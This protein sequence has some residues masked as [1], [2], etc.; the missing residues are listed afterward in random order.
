MLTAAQLD[1]SIRESALSSFRLYLSRRT[2]FTNLDLLRLWKGLFSCMWLTANPLPQQRLAQDLASLVPG[3]LHD[4]NVLIFLDTFWETMSREWGGIDYL[5]I[6]K[7]M[8]LARLMLREQLAWLKRKD[9]DAEQVEKHNGI[10]T[11]TPLNVDNAKIPNGLRY[12]VL[13]VFVDELEKVSESSANSRLKEQSEM[14]L[15]KLLE[16]VAELAKKSPLKP[17]RERAKNAL[18]DDR[19]KEWNKAGAPQTLSGAEGE[20]DSGS[21]W[22]GFEDD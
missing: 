14:P 9:W 22:S 1:P 19:L 11:K 8:Y 21:D 12:H 15:G 13:D 18:A 5:R 16:P 17:T 20:Q 10:L 7:Y 3:T 2:S 6:N 4:S